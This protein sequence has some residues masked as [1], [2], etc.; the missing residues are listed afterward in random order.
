MNK[1]RILILLLVTILLTGCV[2]YDLNM[3]VGSDKS[4]TLT[5]I[6]AIEKEYAESFDP[7]SNTENYENLGFEVEEYNDA[8]Y[9]G[10]KLTKKFTSI[11]EISS[12]DCTTFELTNLIEAN[13]DSIKL[14]KSNKIGTVTTYIAS[15]TYDLTV[16][17]TDTTTEEVDYTEYTDTMIFKYTISLPDSA[18]IVNENADE[19]SNNDHILTWNMKYGELKEI[20]F[21]FNID[22]ND[23]TAPIINNNQTT[24][25]NTNNDNTNNVDTEEETTTKETSYSIDSG[26]NVFGTIIG[27]LLVVVLVLGTIVHKIKNKKERVTPT[28][29]MTHKQPPRNRKE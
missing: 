11:D 25:N 16:E 5:L 15:F 18:V 17:E 4:F 23:V 7:S 6:D 22:D 24:N 14:F 12:S 27:S 20:N 9:I 26:K 3:G 21:T 29:A 10:L 1:K 19:K 2:K 28:I 8:T 13:Q